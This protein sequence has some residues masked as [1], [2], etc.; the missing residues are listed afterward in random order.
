MK[1]YYTHLKKIKNKKLRIVISV[2]VGAVFAVYCAYAYIKTGTIAPSA[3]LI[4]GRPTVRFIDVGQG[5]SALVTY[6]GESVLVDAGP[7][8]AGK[9]VAEYV[10]T[11]SPNVDYFIISHP[12]EDHMGGASDILRTVRVENLVINAYTSDDNFY[13]ETLEIA[14]EQGINIIVADEPMTL[15]T[16]NIMINILDN[17]GYVYDDINDTSLIVRVDVDDISVLFTGD[18]EKTAES[19]VMS[20]SYSMLDADIL[21]VGHHGS[22]TST[23][24]EF[25]KAVSPDIAVISCMKN[26]SYGHPSQNVVNLLKKYCIEI[27]RTDRMGTVVIH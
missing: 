22:K 11:Y 10:R 6:K 15:H 18:A 3:E 24:E 4:D 2:F 13:I 7:A 16:D 8:S 9:S 12:H 19:N 5:D 20:T 25:L 17:F 27:Y 21:K 23:S 26:N 1:K 14:E